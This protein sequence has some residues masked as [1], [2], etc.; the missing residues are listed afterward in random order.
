SGP[1]AAVLIAIKGVSSTTVRFLSA[2]RSQRYDNYRL[3]FALESAVDPAY[4]LVMQFKAELAG[5]RTVDVVLAGVSTECSQKVH[6]LLA[7][8][9]MLR[10]EDRIVV[11]A[12]ADIVPVDTWLAQLIRPVAHGET[13]SACGYRWQ[14]AV[15]REW[16][17][18]I[19]AAADWSV[20]TAAR[21][22]MWNLCWGGSLA[23]GREALEQ[24]DLPRVWA[25]A[26]SDDLTLTRALRAKAL[27]IYVPPFVLVP[28]PISYDWGNLFRFM[29]RQ[30]LLIRV[31]APRHWLFAAV[32]L[33]IPAFGAMLA[34]A[35]ACRGQWWSLTFTVASILLL[36]IR[37]SVRRSIAYLV[38]PPADIPTVLTTVKFARWA[39]P[40]IHLI[41]TSALASSAFGRRFSWAGTRYELDGLKVHV[42]GEP[43]EVKNV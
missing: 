26:A 38:L 12:D 10:Q 29:H 30:Y 28:S 8:L 3:I 34:I 11:F 24:L 22:R 17:S 23:L 33:A 7:A 42:R 31:Y 5:E 40:L 35:L 1:R 37:L 25:R 16:P 32:T 9:R 20:A 36:Q 19:L 18:L 39:W 41:H 6:N 14:L 27:R 21:S 2:L 43:R 13:A 15:K 4:A